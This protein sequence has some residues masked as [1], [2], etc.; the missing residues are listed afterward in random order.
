MALG[1]P[2]LASD[3]PC[4]REAL[5]SS[6]LFAPADDG[7]AWARA[8]LQ[9]LDERS[10]RANAARRRF[11]AIERSWDDIASDYVDLVY[12]AMGRR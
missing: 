10:Q 8:L 5:G 4:A 7:A 12:E 1:V 11:Q 2:A 3:V 9:I 6:A